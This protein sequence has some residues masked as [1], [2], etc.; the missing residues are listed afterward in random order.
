L[1]DL[2]GHCMTTSMVGYSSDSGSSCNVTALVYVL[3]SALLWA[4]RVPTL[5]LFCSVP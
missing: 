2:E 3:L 5:Q 4:T 1:D